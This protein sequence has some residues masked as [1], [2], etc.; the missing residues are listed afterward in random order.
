MKRARRPWEASGRY[1]CPSERLLRWLEDTASN[2]LRVSERRTVEVDGFTR[3]V[4]RL[5]DEHVEEREV[6]RF[7][8]HVPLFS[9]RAAAGNLGEEMAAEA[10]DW[11][12]A[13]EGMSLSP[14]LFVAHVVGR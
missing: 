13:P 3:T 2:A 4:E 10:E 6:R 11:V 8:T 5:F 1:S 14:D 12:P 9:L 7:E